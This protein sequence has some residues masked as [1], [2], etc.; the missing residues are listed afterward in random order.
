MVK[1]S[2]KDH[3]IRNSAWV[4][5]HR[6][7]LWVDFHK[8]ANFVLDNM[9]YVY[10]KKGEDFKDIEI[11]LQKASQCREP[12]YDL[13]TDSDRDYIAYK[14][15]K[16]ELLLSKG[17]LIISS[18]GNVGS[19]KQDVYEELLWL[20][21]NQIETVIADYPSTHIFNNPSDNLLALSV[22]ADVY[23]SLLD[24]KTFNVRSTVAATT[25][26]RKISFPPNWEKLYEQW[27][28][29]EISTKEF[30]KQSGLKKGTF[31]NLVNE[32]REIQAINQNSHNV[33]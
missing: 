14:Q 25:G 23:A 3:L 5:W 13:Y 12:Y 2:E 24:N 10:V 18:I 16:K 33:V 11:L 32:Y 4:N 26:R 30:I 6:N 8:R 7:E 1:E 28:R 9:I 19:N 15:L 22:I 29:R 31:Y 21:N 27:D 17:L 20:K